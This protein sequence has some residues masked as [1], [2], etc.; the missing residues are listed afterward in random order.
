[1][2]SDLDLYCVNHPD[3][4]TRVRCS[5]CNNPICTQCMRETV[6]GMKCPSCARVP[7]RVRYGKPKHYLLAVGGG[8]GVAAIMGAVLSL[9]RFGLLGF[10]IPVL[11][12]AA[13]GEVVR[14]ASGRRGERIFQV[15]AAATTVG[16]LA[17]GAVVV[18]VPLLFLLSPGWLISAA[19][20]SLFAALRAGA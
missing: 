20:A 14:R 11:I 15:I 9:F 12:G 3:R 1:V 4:T 10:F 19:I 2:A 13:V 16:G 7:A 6:V 8:L 17:L 18:G 5:S